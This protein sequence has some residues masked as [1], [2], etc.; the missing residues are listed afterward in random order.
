ME[1]DISMED[2]QLIEVVTTVVNGVLKLRQCMQEFR[3]DNENQ[4]NVD[5]HSNK[6]KSKTSICCL[7]FSLSHMVQ[8]E[9][10]LGRI[11]A[12]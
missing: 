4:E 5:D 7:T 9:A 3:E 12:S 6:K 10:I 1:K 2:V 11:L 8:S